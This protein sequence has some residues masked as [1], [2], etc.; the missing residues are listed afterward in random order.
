VI[1]AARVDSH[2][3]LQQ[4]R[5]LVVDDVPADARL[6]AALLEAAGYAHVACIGDAAAALQ[7]HRGEPFDLILLDLLMPGM[8]G[9]QFLEA[10]RAG[11]DRGAVAAIVMTSAHDQVKRALEAG[12][13]DFI[14]KPVSAVELVPRVRNALQLELLLRGAQSELADAQHRYRALVEQSIAGIYIVEDDRYTYANPR[15]CELLGYGPEE[16]VGKPTLETIAEDERARVLANRARR[17]TD[18]SSLV[19]TYRMRHKDGS[20]VVLSFDGRLIDLKGRRAVFGVALDMTESV[21]AE[22]ALQAAYRR[23]RTLSDRVLSVQEEERRRISRELHDD[24]GQS[25]VALGIGLHRIAAHVP[26]AQRALLDECVAVAGA[27]REKLREI[28]LELHPPHLDQ[29]G[30]HDAL[31]WLAGR[32]SEATGIAIECR[33]DASPWPQ[34]APAVEAACYRI[35]QEA[36]NNAAR[37]AAASL[38]TVELTCGEGEIAVRVSDDGVGFD[39]A[40]RRDNQ[41][42]SGNLGLLSMEERARLAGGRLDVRSARGGGTCV[43]AIF[44]ARAREPGGVGSP[45]LA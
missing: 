8:D 25:M 10:L 4:A 30:L 26:Q 3:Q 11:E 33:F 34:V 20:V 38:V 36:L 35:C 14:A 5:I 21:R 17:L 31:R 29:L 2:P 42:K 41:A 9:L 40:Q 44:P 16:L 15:M 18:P 45:L 1:S 23:L 13:R 7:R 43:A 19:A 27:V 28:S 32:Q 37:H 22:Q 39:Q 12:A 24:V 6:V